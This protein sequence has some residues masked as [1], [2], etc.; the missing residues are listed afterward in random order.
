MENEVEVVVKKINKLFIEHGW[1]IPKQKLQIFIDSLEKILTDCHDKH[2]P[3]DYFEV[4]KKLRNKL[5]TTQTVIRKTDKSKVFCLGRNYD[6]KVKAQ[7]Y[8]NKTKAYQDLGTFNP[9]ESLVEQTN[10][11]LRGLWVNKHITQMQYENL[12]VKKEEAELAHLYLLPKVHKPKTP[13][14]PIMSGL[15][16]PTIAISRWLDGLLRPLFDRVALDTTI[17]NG[18][19]LL[20]QVERWSAKNLTQATSFITMDVTDLYTMIPQEGGITALKRLIEAS[21][22]KQ[23]D[24]VKKEMILALARFVMTNNYF[25]LD[26][27]YYKQI[28]GGAMGSP[29]TLTISNAY[30]YFVERPIEKWAKRTCSLYYRYIDDLF[31][32]SNVHV[33]ILKG[34][35]QFWNRID[36]NIEL[37]ESIGPSAEYLD[38]KLENNGGKL[39]SSVFHKPSH[40]PYFLPFTSIHPRHIK[41]NIPYVA[42]VRAIR[43]SFNFEAYKREEAHICMSL[44]LN[45]YPINFILKQFRRVLQTFECAV[46][47]RMNYLNIRKVFLDTADNKA[48]TAKINFE[49]NIL[50]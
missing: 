24:G 43:Y 20:K 37:S 4:I 2:P 6:Y 8:M 15:K 10:N 5:E 14:R 9:L 47:T 42:L 38:I 3:S 49:V 12:K 13:L 1:V 34:L 28:R 39:V 40:E 23:I 33:D 30:M 7:A 18:V 46:P 48:K 25:Y 22:L 21:G 50:T 19:Q 36:I 45:K 44:L 35:V 41:K 31:I 26:G 11:F 27:S 16:S 17:P 32:M 29:L